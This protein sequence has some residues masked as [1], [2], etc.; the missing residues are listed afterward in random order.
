VTDVNSYPL[1][2]GKYTSL[3]KDFD[4]QA[5]AACILSLPELADG[6]GRLIQPSL[7]SIPASQRFRQLRCNY[8][9]SVV[10]GWRNFGRDNRI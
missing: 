3:V 7:R 1:H 8:G 9:V 5:F 6:F 10:Q 4:A 2:K